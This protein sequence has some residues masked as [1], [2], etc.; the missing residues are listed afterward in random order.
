MTID[1]L[2]EL[3]IFASFTSDEISQIYLLMDD[4]NILKG[5]TLFKEGDKG[6]TMYIVLMG[7]I[8]IS[9]NVGDGEEVEVSRIGEGSFF[10]EMSIFDKAVRSATCRATED[11]DLIS[12]NEKGFH[13][14]ME[15]TPAIAIKMMLRML[16]T[17]SERLQQTGALL[18]DMVKWGEKAQ[19]RAVTDD[20]TGLYNRRF[21]DDSL[22]ESIADAMKNEYPLSLVMM[23]L[24]R[25]GTLN[26]EYGE[27]VGDTV[28][29][30]A[31]GV[32]RKVFDKDEILVR[33]GGDEFAFILPK[34]DGE[35]ALN[36]CRQVLEG[37]HKIDILQGKQGSIQTVSASIGIAACPDHGRTVDELMRNADRAVYFSKEDGRDRATLYN[38]NRNSQRKTRLP[39]SRKRTILF[40]KF[41]AVI[42][43]CSS[44]LVVG[45]KNPDDD[46]M[47]A[48]IAFSSILSK[49]SVKA[50]VAMS[51]NS[52]SEY[53]VLI[54]SSLNDYIQI[55][56]TP[57]SLARDYDAVVILDTPKPSMLEFRDQI[58][59]LIGREDIIVMEIDHHLEADGYYIGDEGYRLVD[60]ASSTCEL[61]GR[62]ALSL[63]RRRKLLRKFRIKEI[64]TQALLTAIL[65][66]ISGDSQ[67]GKFLKGHG[68]KHIYRQ[69]KKLH[70]RSS[71]RIGQDTDIPSYKRVIH[72]L[73]S[74]L[75]S[76]KACYQEFLPHKQSKGM[77]SWIALNEQE[78]DALN[79]SYGVKA[80]QSA[81][82]ACANVL[83]E[84]SG[85]LSLIAY[86]EDVS[87]SDLIQIRMRRSKE[88]KD[89]DL[90]EVIEKFDLVKGGGHEGA[91]GFRLSRNKVENYKLFIDKIINGVLKMI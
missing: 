5:E 18:S 46:C 10:G 75:G 40:N 73:R 82:R 84:E 3:G 53:S 63:S 21:F 43:R 23:D 27:D 19:L 38:L 81:A 25:F 70:A 50:T 2:N 30:A 44:A 74:V 24:D 37:L 32:F 51:Q 26:K 67:N 34:S 64:L 39:N 48:L 90:R 7:E 49:F 65:V 4:I 55:A 13:T 91:I 71:R 36:S 88:F 12:L 59:S 62:F 28:I 1:A 68:E 8:A 58:H 78:S 66:G 60:T 61:I 79:K 17:T 54:D 56:E 83:A 47:A 33:Y 85:Y 16:N 76:E 20:F 35:T 80:V 89:L 15:E 45:H 14:L 52:R 11:C 57:G 72:A 6:K 86:Y 31:V 41:A 42:S 77:I 29:L 9:I 69:F 87:L 22:K